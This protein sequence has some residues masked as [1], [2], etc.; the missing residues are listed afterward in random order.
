MVRFEVN[1]TSVILE[2]TPE[3]NGPEWVQRE[4][5]AYGKVTVS[6]AFTFTTADLLQ[7]PGEATEDQVDEPLF[8]FRFAARRGGYFRIPGRI[9]GIANEVLVAET[10]WLERK[11]F[12]AERN[13]GIFGRI[14]KI[15]QDESAI[16]IGGEDE[17]AIPEPVFR[18]LLDRFPTTGE[19]DRYAA[20]RI[21]TILGEF[22]DEMRSA[23]ENYEAYLNRRPPIVSD[24]PLAQHELLQAEIDKFVYV[25][26]TIVAWLRTAETYSERDWQRMIVKVILLILP[27]YVAVLENVTIADFYTNEGRRHPRYI[28]ICL[29]DAGGNLDLI[30]IKRPFNDVILGKKPYRGNSLPTRELAGSIMQ[31]EKYLF[32]LSKWG[33][34]GERELT[35]QHHAQLPADL[36]IRVT[37]PKAM[38]L[39]GRD[40]LADGQPALSPRQR[41]DF[42]VIKRKYANIIDILTYDDLIRRLDNIIASL[43]RRRDA[44]E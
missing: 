26:D 41:L 7:A 22:F 35:R 42:E 31:A 29:V 4:L 39:L 2:Y 28:D 15:K 13:I 21:E 11:F 14:A 1:R 27:K 3:F 6:R 10:I 40:Q 33:V 37:N 24:R 17:D 44:A 19:V 36:A 8:R 18:E 9:L 34:D 25:R 30:E 43:A 16:I 20:A 32:H 12:V 5:Q 23:R 38:I